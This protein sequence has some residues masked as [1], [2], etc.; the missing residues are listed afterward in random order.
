MKFQST[1]LL[2]TT[3]LVINIALGQLSFDIYPKA[4][5]LCVTDEALR[6][7]CNLQSTAYSA[8]ICLCSNGGDFVNKTAVCVA[9]NDPTDLNSVYTVMLR[10]CSSTN[11][12]LGFTEEQFISAGQA[13]TKTTSTSSA[14]S[15]SP[16]SSTSSAPSTS[17]NTNT[18]SHELQPTS[19][20]SPAGT[21]LGSSSSS[22]GGGGGGNVGHLS[23]GAIGLISAVAAIVSLIIAFLTW[24]GCKRRRRARPSI[25]A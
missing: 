22:S 20:A 23:G 17:T 15:T 7:G 3:H 11:T 16:A 14:S 12:P 9:S 13:S 2:F 21:A 8:N 4:S 10:A 25:F 19:A 1:Y 18:Q 24:C 5:Q 6:S